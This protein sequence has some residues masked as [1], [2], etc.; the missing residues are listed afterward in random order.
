MKEREQEIN[1]LSAEKTQQDANEQSTIETANSELAKLK[2]ENKA[3]HNELSAFRSL[4]PGVGVFSVNKSA[5]STPSADRDLNSVNSSSVSLP[6]SVSPST[7]AQ[8]GPN[9][10]R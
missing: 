1:D 9:K 8:L 2:E 10:S 4:P 3:L 7:A 5:T 6:S